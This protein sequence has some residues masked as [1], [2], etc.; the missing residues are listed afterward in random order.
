MRLNSIKLENIRSYRFQELKFLDGITLLSGDIGSGKSTI[1]KS[2]DFALFGLR[3]GE[4]SGSDLLRH[5]KD[6][7]S[8]ELDFNIKEKNIIIK[9]TLKRS[10]SSVSQDA[11]FL[12]VNSQRLDATPIELKQ[13]ILDL[14]NYPKDMLTKKSMIFRYTVYTPQEEMKQILLSDKDSRLDI[15]RKVFDIDK[16]KI[17][18]TNCELFL[19]SLRQKKRELESFTQDLEPKLKQRAEK[20]LEIKS[21]KDSLILAEK[22]VNNLRIILNEKKS[23]LDLI[24]NKIEE[25]NVVTKEFEINENSLKHKESSLKTYETTIERLNQ[26]L[27]SINLEISS[28]PDQKN[29]EISPEEL[30]KKIQE[31]ETDIREL[32]DKIQ[33]AKVLIARSKMTIDQVLSLQNCPTCMQAVTHDYKTNIC[34]KEN[35]SIADNESKIKE[36]E[37]NESLLARELIKKKDELDSLKKARHSFE[38]ISLKRKSFN[39]KQEQ[40]NISI[41]DSEIIKKEILNLKDKKQKLTIDLAR[42]KDIH[43]L[44]ETK[45]Q[46]YELA[47]KSLR[48]LEMKHL[49]LAKDIENLN[50]L[51]QILTIDIENKQKAKVH[52][53]NIMEMHHWISEYFISLM[54]EMESQVMKKI[55]LDFDQSFQ[56]WFSLLIRE[57][58][59]SIA[60]D[61]DF[62][63]FIQQNGYDVEYNALS[64]GEKTAIAL[65]YRLALNE[66]ITS[67][68]SNINTTDLLILDEPTDGFS[69]EQL[70]RLQSVLKTLAT[71]QIILVSHENKIESYADNLIKLEKLNHETIFN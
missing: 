60:L 68:M 38:L 30:G 50:S 3:K 35:S 25:L 61:D 55:H 65:A 66:I 21:V 39:E 31:H 59:I 14:L 28:M 46:E 69:S 20:E 58:L 45:K 6:S 63:P 19:T 48:S 67:I 44:H 42:L 57:D 22:E 17:I 23:A 62:T 41:N 29:I 40:K 53:E 47:D 16:Y 54:S 43:S 11:G 56:R 64:G 51:V 70:E 9:R 36:F 8:V 10:Q 33:E 18:S 24:S 26:E 2:I 1:L 13:H 7:G 49:S 52:I 71:K 15:L 32:R 5:G 27:K 12:M 34:A 4:L 37:I